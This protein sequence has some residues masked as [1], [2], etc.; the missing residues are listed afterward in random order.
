MLQL[1]VYKKYIQN[2]ILFTKM[3]FAL[4]IKFVNLVFFLYKKNNIQC[5]DVL[6][7]LFFLTF[8][9]M[10]MT[11]NNLLILLHTKQHLGKLTKVI[12][13]ALEHLVLLLDVIKIG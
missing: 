10:N 8:D 4:K 2:C 3:Y 5:K 7:L 9:I 13:F 6:L 11:Q 12:I 1:N